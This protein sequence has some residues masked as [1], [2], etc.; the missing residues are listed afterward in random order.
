MEEEKK[1]D[2]CGLERIKSIITRELEQFSTAELNQDAL[3]TLYKLV[4]IC[5]D[6][7]NIDY[8]N[9]KKEELKYEIQQLRRL[10]RRKIW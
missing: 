2:T 5:K 3:D 10:F 1:E 7:E 6:L 4:D 8:W 9:V